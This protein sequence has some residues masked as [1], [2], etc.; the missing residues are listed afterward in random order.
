[1]TNIRFREKFGEFFEIVILRGFVLLDFSARFALV[2]NYVTF[3]PIYFKR[4]GFH[5]ATAVGEAV[6]GQFFVYME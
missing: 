1:M 2:R 3:L 5:P 6:A 4:D